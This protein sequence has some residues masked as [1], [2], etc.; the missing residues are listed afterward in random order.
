VLKGI[1]TCSMPISYYQ[2]LSVI[3]TPTHSFPSTTISHQKNTQ[4]P[5]SEVYQLTHGV[6]SACLSCYLSSPF[7]LQCSAIGNEVGSPRFM[8]TTGRIFRAIR[9]WTT[10]L[11]F[12][13]IF[14]SLIGIVGMRSGLIIRCWMGWQGFRDLTRRISHIHVGVG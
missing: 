11:G 7:N 3:P 4:N 12:L 8:I 5:Y 13:G 10:T 14:A 2:S 9:S 1:T 6:L